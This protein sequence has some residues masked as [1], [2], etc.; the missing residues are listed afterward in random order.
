MFMPIHS[1]GTLMIGNG[2][3]GTDAGVW[4]ECALTLG[5]PLAE[6]MDHSDHPQP[7]ET[8]AD[9]LQSVLHPQGCMWAK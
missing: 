2:I 6:L 5:A 3:K 4:G 9:L 7:E 8:V 1:I